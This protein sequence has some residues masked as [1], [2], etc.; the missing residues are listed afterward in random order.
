[1]QCKGNLKLHI[2]LRVSTMS[3]IAGDYPNNNDRQGLHS[4]FRLLKIKELYDGLTMES[5]SPGCLPG[6]CFWKLSIKIKK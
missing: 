1:M 5:N 3:P 6:C 4:I 2:H